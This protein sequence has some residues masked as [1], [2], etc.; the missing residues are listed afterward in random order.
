MITIDITGRTPI[1][2]QIYRAV[3][4]E[5][6]RGL[7][8]ENDRL[9]PS[10]ALAQQLSLNPNTVAKAYQMLERDGIIYTMAGKGSFVAPMNGKASSALTRDFEEKASS[11]MKAGVSAET[12]IEIIRKLGIENDI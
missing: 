6:T 2:E 3:C 12:L 7:L 8:N 11:L 5:I 1:Y 10:R 4:G 9:P